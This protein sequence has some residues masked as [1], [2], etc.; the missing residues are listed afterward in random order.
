V[1]RIQPV[2]H[3]VPMPAVVPHE[4]RLSDHAKGRQ[5]A[6]RDSLTTGA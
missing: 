2:F 1:D 4:S 6:Q 3:S 5:S